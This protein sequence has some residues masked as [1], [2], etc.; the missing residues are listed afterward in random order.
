MA[1]VES[2]R[3]VM[4]VVHTQN[5]HL[6]EGNRPAWSRV[7]AAGVFEISAT[8]G[9]F[10]RHYH[11]CDEYWLV[12]A[13]VARIMTEGVEYV[14]RPGDIVCTKAGD[15]HD[16]VEV[17]EDL[18]AFYFEDA[19]EPGGRLGHLHRTTDLA[20]GHAVRTGDLESLKEL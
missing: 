11:D 4:P 10:D 3:T 13:G 9:R 19:L 2:E 8:G 18:R 20:E 14:V 1:L 7:T 6:A 12:F 15:E 17:Y 16:V 5:A